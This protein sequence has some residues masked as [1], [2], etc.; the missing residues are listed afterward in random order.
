MR[1]ICCAPSLGSLLINH[2]RCVVKGEKD[3]TLNAGFSVN[4][5]AAEVGIS[6]HEPS[7]LTIEGE[8]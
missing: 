8:S 4:T 5:T 3:A 6:S 7:G 1:Y 2:I